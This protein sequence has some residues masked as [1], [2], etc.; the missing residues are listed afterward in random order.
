[1]KLRNTVSECGEQTC[2]ADGHI[3]PALSAGEDLCLFT[4]LHHDLFQVAGGFQQ[5]PDQRIGVLADAVRQHQ[6]DVI[7]A[8]LHLPYRC[9]ALRFQSEGKRHGADA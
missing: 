9:F 6:N 1:M 3:I 2:G 5:L 4:D 8:E 7:G